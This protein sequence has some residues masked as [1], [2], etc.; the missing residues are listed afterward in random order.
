MA[1]TPMIAVA[2]NTPRITMIASNPT[3][4]APEACRLRAVRAELRA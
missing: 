1:F 2:I 3:S 4:D